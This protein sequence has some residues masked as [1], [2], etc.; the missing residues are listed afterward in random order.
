M[1]KALKVKS[2][3]ARVMA[4]GWWLRLKAR[5]LDFSGARKCL[6]VPTGAQSPLCDVVE[7][8]VLTVES[9]FAFAFCLCHA[10]I[11]LHST[12]DAPDC[13]AQTWISP[14]KHPATHSSALFMQ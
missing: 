3:M 5:K 14:A 2:K 13:E 6:V 7:W 11:H 10:S 4:G 12:K 1:I 9:P 8:A